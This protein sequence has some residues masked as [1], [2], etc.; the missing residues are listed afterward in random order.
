MI[1]FFILSKTLS[2]SL[3]GSKLAV[4]KQFNTKKKH[5]FQLNVSARYTLHFT[6]VAIDKPKQISTNFSLSLLC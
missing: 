6:N 1:A 5:N 4:R 3:C 2:R